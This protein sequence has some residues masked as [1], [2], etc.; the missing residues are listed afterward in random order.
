MASKQAP[1][2]SA[3]KLTK[4]ERAAQRQEKAR[5][6]REQEAKRRSRNRTV[7]ISACVVAIVV[8]AFVVVKLVSSSG[9]VAQAK[10][11]TPSYGIAVTAQGAATTATKSGVPTI[12]IF[13]DPTCPHCVEFHSAS[14]DAFARHIAAGDINVVYQPVAIGPIGPQ[15]IDQGNWGVAAEFYVAT[16]APQQFGAFHDALMDHSKGLFALISKVATEGKGDLPGK[17][18]IKAYAQQAGV[19]ADVADGMVRALGAPEWN[20]YLK[21]VLQG[22]RSAGATGTPTVMVDGKIVENY[23]NTNAAIATWLDQVATGKVK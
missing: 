10:N 3:A 11:V 17:E 13:E 21:K 19:P 18:Q 12:Q 20:N 7:I 22:F 14:K 23:G 16:H 8:I 5:I 1:G 6:L 9:A 2:T 4:T 15:Y